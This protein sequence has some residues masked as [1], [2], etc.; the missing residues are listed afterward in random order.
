MVTV[1]FQFLLG[2]L[3]TEPSLDEYVMHWQFQFLLGR[4][5]THIVCRKDVFSMGVSIPLRQVKNRDR[6]D[7]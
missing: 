3:K 7:I 4:L 1:G 6:F 2:R 5:K